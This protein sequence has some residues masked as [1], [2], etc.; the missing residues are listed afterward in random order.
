MALADDIATDW[1]VFDGVEE[2]T[3]TNRKHD[4]SADGAAANG[5]KALRRVLKRSEINAYGDLRLEPTDIVWN[6]WVATLGGLTPSFGST[7]TDS[8]G[9]IWQVIALDLVT[10]GTRWRC[11]CRKNV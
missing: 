11:V 10:M 1:Q 7:I 6:L 4:A 8:A 3:V 2:V 9:A 5:V